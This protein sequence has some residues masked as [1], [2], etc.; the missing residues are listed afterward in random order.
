MPAASVTVSVTLTGAPISLQS[1]SVISALKVKLQLSDDP[2]L[3]SAATI[4]AWPVL[5]KSILIFL[6]WAFGKISSLTVTVVLQVDVFPLLSSTV[7]VT[8]LSPRS[9]QVK[10]LGA[11]LMLAIAQLSVE[12]PS[13]CEANKVALPLASN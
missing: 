1:K 10:V 6:H 12:P 8:L 4:L 3:I 11:T 13:T 9:L 5:S 2:L 7:R